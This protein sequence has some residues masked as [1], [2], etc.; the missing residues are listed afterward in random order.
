MKLDWVLAGAGWLAVS[1]AA[2]CA[3]GQQSS[4]P[5]FQSAAAVAAWKAYQEGV[6]KQDQAYQT[7]RT[8]LQADY[9]AQLAAA[10][11]AAMAAKNLDEANRIR[12][13]L[14]RIGRAAVEP[15]QSVPGTRVPAGLLRAVAGTW[16]AKW[17]TTSSE[18]TFQIRPDGTYIGKTGTRPLLYVAGQLLFPDGAGGWIEVLPRN[19]KLILLNWESSN[20]DVR[21]RPPNHVGV[22]VSAR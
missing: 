16:K 2:S 18:W 5:A 6:A 20:R 1:F 22:A 19:G 3:V 9:A 11:D 21:T 15:G 10:F 14:E 12:D 4:Q 17:Y 7:A 8:A 13:E